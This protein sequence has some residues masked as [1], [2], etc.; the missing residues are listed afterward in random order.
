MTG[1][2][3]SPPRPRYG[4]IAAFGVATLVT[5]LSGL[6]G[7]GVLSTGAR[8]SA[9]Q[10]AHPAS[11]VAPTPTTQNTRPTADP[12]SSS[13]TQTSSTQTTSTGWSHAGALSGGRLMGAPGQPA[14]PAASGTGRRIV[15][16]QHLQ[17]VWLVGKGE[18]AKRTY[19]VSG[20]L[21]DNLQPGT[22]QV[23]S[24][25]QNATGLGDS[26]VMTHFVRFTQGPTGAAIGFHSI[27]TKDGQ[28]LQ[29]VNQLGSPESHGC[30]RQWLPD[31]VA[32][33]N[34][35]PIGTTVV[36]LT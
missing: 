20:S 2:R 29:T 15:F 33:W 17:R 32:L 6:G 1:H 12:S 18:Q 21:T 31:A 22:Y 13:S 27:P 34:F 4:R 9:E 25:S 35:A 14:V 24:R 28:P 5:M 19:L 7:L 36:V 3:G 23:Y 16:S 26:G 10:V 8:A 11:Y 30:I